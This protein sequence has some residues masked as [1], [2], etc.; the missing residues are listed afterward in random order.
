MI[1][2]VDPEELKNVLRPTVYAASIDSISATFARECGATGRGR[3]PVA[4]PA[5]IE[6]IRK[7]ADGPDR[8]LVSDGS[9]LRGA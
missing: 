4:T 8:R 6:S 3:S 7:A 2:I 1:S 9:V 5:E